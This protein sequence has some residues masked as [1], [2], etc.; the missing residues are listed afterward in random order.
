MINLHDLL[1][2]WGFTAHPFDAY[3]AE[4]E[5]K[6]TDYFVS[7]PYLGDILGSP[8]TAAPSI[9]FGARGIGKS[10][11]RIAVEN[12]CRTKDQ[13][14]LR[15]SVEA[16]TYDDFPT[17]HPTNSELPTLEDHLKTITKKILHSATHQIC[18][19]LDGSIPSHEAIKNRFPQLNQKLFA[20]LLTRH[21]TPAYADHQE[22]SFQ[23]TYTYF[24]GIATTLL[25]RL[26]SIQI[27]WTK[28]RQ[29]IFDVIV[30]TQALKGKEPPPPL[31]SIDTITRSTQSTHLLAAGDFN[32]LSQLAP[33]LGLDAWYILID[34]VDEDERTNSDA[35]K[36]AN[37]IIPLLKN[38]KTLETPRISFKFFLWDQLRPLLT[39]E[40][41][42]LDKIK[43]WSMTWTD[44]ELQEMINL[45]L[46]VFSKGK[47]TTLD[48]IC[49]PDASRTIYKEVL[50]HA[51]NA[52]REIVQIL[53]S[54]FREHARHHDTHN[55]S[56][57]ISRES[58]ERGLDDYCRRRISDM[59]PPEVPK[60]ISKLPQA[61]FTNA[62]IQRTFHIAQSAASKKINNWLDNGYITRTNDAR[63]TKDP[64]KTVYQYIVSEPRLLR[65]LRRRLIK[66][67]SFERESED[68]SEQHL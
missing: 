38:L 43:N 64:S 60:Q 1:D 13:T 18:T 65:I 54:I 10:A 21:I 2:H 14:R 24:K 12:A 15:G 55:S 25:Q 16:I 36:S 57:L 47:T 48:A 26:I 19:S 45:R 61:K 58:I 7:P 44:H 46:T 68:E 9:V 23:A 41:I 49:E 67:S 28:I 3:T 63:S 6:L 31:S 37:L 17:A 62:D 50:T 39:N 27:A 20:K 32:L 53:D 66:P 4:K 5:T 35:A 34:K 59:Y 22:P 33:Q 29:L 51:T 40:D 52:P 56:L 8:S 11:L 42:R 30:F